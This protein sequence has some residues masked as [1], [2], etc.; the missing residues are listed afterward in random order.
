MKHRRL[1]KNKTGEN[2]SKFFNMAC[3]TVK[4][5][6]KDILNNLKDEQE[7]LTDFET[8]NQDLILG[9]FAD[10]ATH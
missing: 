7:L 2:K 3:L 4:D 8:K 10:S 5:I 6:Q 9:H 1:I